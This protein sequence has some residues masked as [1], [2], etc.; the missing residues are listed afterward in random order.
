MFG[1]N[2][3][4]Q[5]LELGSVPAGCQ[6][7]RLTIKKMW[8][9]LT[10]RLLHGWVTVCGQEKYRQ[11]VEKSVSQRWQHERSIRFL[12][13]KFEHRRQHYFNKTA[14]LTFLNFVIN[15]FCAITEQIRRR[16]NA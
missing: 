15:P 13:V 6:T 4:S 9:R 7:V 8:I 5:R 16:M 11:R 10:I 1:P 14:Y 3:M 2:V 12:S